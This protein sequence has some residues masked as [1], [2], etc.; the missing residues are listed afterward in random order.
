MKFIYFVI[1]T[2]IS[3]KFFPL[4]IKAVKTVGKLIKSIVR[5]RLEGNYGI[6]LKL[7]QFKSGLPN[8]PASI[9]RKSSN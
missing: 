8:P 3:K 5:R 2:K 6:G 1:E 9:R 4:R 7:R